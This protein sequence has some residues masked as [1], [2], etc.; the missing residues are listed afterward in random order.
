MPN[1]LNRS[2]AVD[3]RT[4]CKCSEWGDLWDRTAASKVN[5]RTKN[6]LKAVDLTRALVETFGDR[7]FANGNNLGVGI[8]G[9]GVI[10]QVTLSELNASYAAVRNLAYIKLVDSGWQFTSTVPSTSGTPNTPVDLGTTIDSVVE[11]V[12]RTVPDL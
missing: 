10:Q 6:Y 9:T 8:F 1:D 5:N 2:Y 7:K 11:Y 12:A 3:L 4:S